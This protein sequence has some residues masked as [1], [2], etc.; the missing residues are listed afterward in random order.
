MEVS[1]WCL[2][3]PSRQNQGYHLANFLRSRLGKD[4]GFMP[5]EGVKNLTFYWNLLVKFEYELFDI[6]QR[7]ALIL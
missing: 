6:M 2:N 1:V 3:W 4:L 7:N 5:M